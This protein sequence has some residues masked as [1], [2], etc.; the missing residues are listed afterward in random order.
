M[1]V[2][3]MDDRNDQQS[4][5]L[6]AQLSNSDAALCRSL[7][8]ALEKEKELCL[9]KSWTTE[10]QKEVLHKRFMDF[11]IRIGREER[12]LSSRFTLSWNRQ[13]KFVIPF[14]T[15]YLFNRAE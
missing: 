8:L 3:F 5:C 15:E 10:S 4:I 1:L 13:R 9:S 12:I 11:A 7:A 2:R 6:T 14:L